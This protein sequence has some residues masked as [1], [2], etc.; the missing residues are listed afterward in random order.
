[1]GGEG[2]PTAVAVVDK[3]IGRGERVWLDVGVW[4]DDLGEATLP[5]ELL[6]LG[7]DTGT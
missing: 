7:G 1:M 5:A 4:T 6:F 2:T 3:G